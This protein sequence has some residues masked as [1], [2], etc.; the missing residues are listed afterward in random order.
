MRKE[1]QRKWDERGGG[2]GTGVRLKE[3][4]RR[5]ERGRRKRRAG[6]SKMFIPLV[7]IS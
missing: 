4:K 1:G 5:N 7:L 3:W 6:R 2:E